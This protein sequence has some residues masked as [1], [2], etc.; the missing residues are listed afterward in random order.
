MIESRAVGRAGRVGALALACALAAGVAAPPTVS[1]EGLEDDV[2]QAAAI[3]ERFRSMPEKQI[4]R[5]IL[6]EAKGLAILTVVKAGFVVS[7]QGGKGVVIAKTS[8]DGWSGPSGIGTGGAGFGFQV[9]AQVTEFVIVLNTPK[10]VEAFSRGGNFAIGADLSAAVG[11]IGR[12]LSADV[13]PMAAVYTY[14]L[15]QGLFAGVSLEGTVIVTRDG[16]NDEYYRRETTPAEILA[17]KITPPTGA[18]ALR[19]VLARL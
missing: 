12:D 3:I 5:K 16:A 11:P 19:Q 7:A 10:A 14:S 6:D 8:S 4:P 18:G 2:E 1:A 17:G 13:L 15:S 9:G